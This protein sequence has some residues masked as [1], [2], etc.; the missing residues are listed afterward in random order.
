MFERRA[1]I[2]ATIGPSSQDEAVLTRLIQAGMEVARLNFS[3]GTH[4]QHEAIIAKIRKISKEL[5]KPVAILQDLQGPKL[6]VGDLPQEGIKL[7]A[8]HKLVLAPVPLP[9]QIKS[10]SADATVIPMEVPNLMGSIKE[11]NRI[12]LDDGQMEL[13]VAQVGE[14]Y[15]EAT[16]VLGGVL[17]SHKGVNLPG[18]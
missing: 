3:H 12:L 14:N 10:L 16:V 2:V 5:G 4:A 9:D 7:T 8:G 1:K 13:V 17:Q 18:A 11:G 6:R 15:L